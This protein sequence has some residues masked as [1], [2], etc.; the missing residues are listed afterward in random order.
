MII[1]PNSPGL[2][3]DDTS[4]IANVARYTTRILT[5]LSRTA[6]RAT[7]VSESLSSPVPR[8]HS[9]R[10]G[11]VAE[12]PPFQALKDGPKEIRRAATIALICSSFTRALG[13][14][15][16]TVIIGTLPTWVPGLL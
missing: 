16:S 4:P 3:W 11:R 14:L 7:R 9:L 13:I 2:N 15:V 6:D 10:G 12:A 1:E 8:P 5:C